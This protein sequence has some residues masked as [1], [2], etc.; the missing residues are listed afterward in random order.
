MGM[1][2]PYPHG[3]QYGLQSLVRRESSHS[4]D[5]LHHGM[6]SSTSNSGTLFVK[7]VENRLFW[8]TGIFCFALFWEVF[9]SLKTFSGKFLKLYMKPPLRIPISREERKHRSSLNCKVYK[10]FKKFPCEMASPKF[11][12]WKGIFPKPW[13]LTFSQSAASQYDFPEKCRHDTSAPRKA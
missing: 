11:Y 9:Y 5:A 6:R 2:S 4:R 7:E 1:R 3:Q 10:K 13:T 12:M 8:Q